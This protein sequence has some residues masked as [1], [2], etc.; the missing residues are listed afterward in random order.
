M[1]QPDFFKQVNDDL[2]KEIL[3][4][5]EYAAAESG[6]IQ[7]ILAG[8]REDNLPFAEM[9]DKDFHHAYS[10]TRFC[11]PEE[12]AELQEAFSERMTPFL[13]EIG[14]VYCQIDPNNDLAVSLFMDACQWMKGSQPEAFEKSAIGRIGLPWK[15]VYIRSVE[16]MRIGRFSI[17]A[18]CKRFHIMTGTVFFDQL[19]LSFLA[20]CEKNELLAN[21]DILTDLIP[22]ANLDFIR[23]AIKNYTAKFRYEEMPQKL[24]EAISMRLSMESKGETL[25]LSPNLL[26]NIRR[27]RFHAAL[28]EAVKENSG[29]LK[30]Y[31]ANIGLIKNIEKIHENYFTIDF[32]SYIVLDNEDWENHAFAYAPQMFPP[33][34]ETWKAGGFSENYWP[35]LQDPEIATARE[36]ILGI[37]KAGVIRLAF[38]EFDILY[39]KDLLNIT[40]Y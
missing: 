23:P 9:P 39:A 16:I 11:A 32:G 20:W 34:Y 33:L 7:R 14:W 2:K 13:F 28:R 21:I 24:S 25:G 10:F 1:L 4:P 17:E 12:F 30:A 26:L 19:R 27:L 38:T 8:K 3:S 35:A 36:I 22:A 5:E 29:K 31:Y 37:K 40:R 6:E 15:D 18:F